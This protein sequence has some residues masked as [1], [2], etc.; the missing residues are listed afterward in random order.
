MIAILHALSNTPKDVKSTE[1]ASP[2]WIAKFLEKCTTTMPPT[3]KATMLE[4]DSVI[5]SFHEAATSDP[6]N[7]TNRPDMSEQLDLHFVTFICVNGKLY[8]LDGRIDGP[9]CHGSTSE[10]DFLKDAC[11]VVREWM[12]ADKDELRFN[13]MAL[14]PVAADK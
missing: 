5:E 9:V 1:I 10:V 13:M 7:Q 14:A 2:S 3:D 12:E 6:A 11:G 4:N 8:E